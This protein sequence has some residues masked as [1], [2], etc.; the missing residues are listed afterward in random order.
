MSRISTI[1]E[2]RKKQSKAALIPFITAG[3]PDMATTVKAMHALVTAGADIIELGVPYSDPMADG[4]VIQHASERALANGATLSKVLD[5]VTTFRADDQATA[6]VLM[7]YLN[8]VEAMGYQNF[9]DNA[10]KA[11]VDGVLIVDLPIDESQ[12]LMPE[13]KAAAIDP[14]ILLAPTSTEQR[15]EKAMSLGQG[16]LYYV[17]FKGITGAANKLDVSDVA[18]KLSAIKQHGDLPVAVGFGINDGPSA[19]DVA[20]VADAV[21]VGSALV[22]FFESN[23][24]DAAIVNASKLLGSMREAIDA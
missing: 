5:A 22:K 23:E 15:I 2:Q 6:V 18:S 19:R 10:K 9:A 7:G 17:S 16:Y 4:P 1:L 8:P 13:L 21:V 20:E 12:D 11:G 24:A 14:I 3:D